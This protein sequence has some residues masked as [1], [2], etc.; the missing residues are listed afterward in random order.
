MKTIK[1]WILFQRLEVGQR[2]HRSG[3]SYHTARR[4]Y[5][6]SPLRMTA[7]KCFELLLRHSPLVNRLT[8]YRRVN[9]QKCFALIF[10][11]RRNRSL[12]ETVDGQQ[13]LG[14]GRALLLIETHQG[15]K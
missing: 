11:G 15:C 9:W 14:G 13:V 2:I 5:F 12:V 10:E 1:Y 6:T 3:P 8:R 7:K 4:H